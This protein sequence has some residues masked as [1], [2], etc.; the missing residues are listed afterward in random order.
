[1][2]VKYI[3]ARVEAWIAEEELPVNGTIKPIGKFDGLYPEDP[4][5]ADAYWDWI[6]FHVGRADLILKS[7]KNPRN[8]PRYWKWVMKLERASAKA[9]AC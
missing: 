7:I 4:V 8:P 3:S 9:G 1:M 2:D 6:R 5:E